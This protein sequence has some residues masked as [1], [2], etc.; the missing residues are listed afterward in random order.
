MK[1]RKFLIY[2]LPVLGG[3]FTF[4]SSKFWR[5]W[6]SQSS[7][8]E[9]AKADVTLSL[10]PNLYQLETV[11]IEGIGCLYVSGGKYS[12]NSTSDPI[13]LSKK[14]RHVFQYLGPHYGW[15]YIG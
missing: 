13:K 7:S 11:M 2:S 5:I 1:R 9:L 12:I 10:E 6:G 4:V 15:M 3:L 14:G 8:H